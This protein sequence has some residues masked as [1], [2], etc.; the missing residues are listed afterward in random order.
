MWTKTII[1][2]LSSALLISA[3]ERPP[4]IVVFLVDDIGWGDVGCN[5]SK[6]HETPAID[7]L[8]KEGIRFTH[9][10][11]ACTVC[12]PSRA[13]I[14][15]GQYPARLHLTDW[16]SGHVKPRAKLKVPD[17]KMYMEHSLTTL[18]EALKSK[19]YATGFFGKWHLMPHR[20]PQLMPEHTPEKHG[21]DVN[22]GGR[23]WGQPKGKGK[24]FHPWNMPGLEGGKEGDFLTDRLT[25][26]SIQWVDGV[27]DKPFFL[28]LSYYAV[29]GPIMTKPELKKKYQDK[30]KGGDYS[31][32][33]AAYAGMIQS[34]DE[35]VGRIMEYLKKNGLAENT[36][37]I[38]T[39]DNG[40]VAESSSG[41]LRKGKAWAYE[42]GT[43]EPF[44]VKWAR[45]VKPGSSSDTPVIGMDI[46]PTILE[47]AGVPQPKGQV[48]DGE[49]LI[50][51]IE[52]GTEIER[53]TLYWHYPHYHKTKPYSAIRKGNWKLIRFH[54]D[55][56]LELYQLSK[57]PSESQNLTEQFSEKAKTLA[58]ELDTW[59]KSVDAQ[60]MTPNPRYE[61]NAKKAKGKKK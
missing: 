18:P 60:H 17:W 46:Y 12:S 25:T 4:N 43:R 27:K 61:P 21:F 7:T 31:Q 9:G 22:V 57:D 54:E 52:K 53:D 16:I 37:V 13:A 23:E 36:L 56:K 19:G 34:V 40:G 29:H 2:L 55:G 30:L 24:Y 51:H 45:K 50:S 10:Y 3:A 33:N 58:A 49:S 35:S 38:F 28:Y 6:F 59:L 32:K 42:G 41:G 44:I 8:A 39:G 1:T 11:A 5:G 47:A 15:T 20:Q 14:M 26:E 48:C